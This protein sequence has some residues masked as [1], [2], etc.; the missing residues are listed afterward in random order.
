MQEDLESILLTRDGRI[1]KNKWL[2]ISNGRI[3]SRHRS[4][5][6]ATDQALIKSSVTGHTYSVGETRIDG[7][8]RPTIFG[9]ATASRSGFFEV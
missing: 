8:G 6:V 1:P 9:V 5:K 7:N 2:L 3:I 4:R